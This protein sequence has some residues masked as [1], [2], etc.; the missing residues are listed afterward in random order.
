M[1]ILKLQTIIIIIIITIII[2]I[3]IIIIIVHKTWR[4]RI[5]N[6]LLESI[7]SVKKNN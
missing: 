3:I 5:V 6:K 2:I 4:N 7:H 1:G